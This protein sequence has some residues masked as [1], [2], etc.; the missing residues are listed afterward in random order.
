MSDMLRLTGLVSGMDTDT[1]IKKLIKV[2]QSKVDQVKQDKQFM[3]WQKEDYREIANAIRAFQDE[4]FDILKPESN[5]RSESN[6]N[7]FSGTAKID[8]ESTSKVSIETT[9]NSIVGNVTVNSVTQLATQDRYTSGAEVLGSIQTGEIGSISLVNLELADNN[10]MEFILDG[11]PKVISLDNQPY[12]DLSALA[13]DLTTKLQEAYQNVDINVSTTGTGD[14][15]LEFQIN[16]SGT[17]TEE[18]GH[19]LE[20]GEMNSDLLQKMQLKSGQSNTVNDTK[21]LAEVFDITGDTSFVI[22][23][24]TFTFS[25]DT[26]ISSVINSINT[27]ANAKVKLNYDK[28]SDKFTLEANEYGTTNSMTIVD[29]T[30]FLRKLK[31]AGG[32]EDHSVAKDS[33]ATING[34]ETT[35]SGNTFDVNGTKITVN[36]LITDDVEIEVTSDPTDTKEKIVKF[37]NAYN[38]MVR[39]INV[40]ADERKNRDFEP[41]TETQREGM[42]ETEV[43]KWEKEARKGTLGD[44]AV[45]ENITRSLRNALY[46]S[47]EGLGISLYDIGIQTSE[48]YKDKGVLTIDEEKLDDA[49]EKRP[50]EVVALFTQTSEITYSSFADRTTRDSQ[51]GIVSRIHDILQD[52]IRITRNKNGVKGYLI[53]KAGLENTE[54]KTSELAKK[55]QEMDE[56]ITN[57]LELLQNREDSLYAQFARMESAMS[58]L[59]SQS[60]WLASQFGGG[61]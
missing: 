21:T 40:K 24:E 4:Y 30:G 15:K 7:M 25:S 29:T 41:L 45:I 31:L 37:V 20:I 35:R 8:G 56:R 57:L 36:E 18:K 32:T 53:E 11:V 1:T 26:K 42:S 61:S 59:S 9:V 10:K 54:D 33:I 34:I 44:D 43:E 60:A 38:E 49:L 27:N 12:A 5:M 19:S 23:G 28:L 48:N 52:N 39:K 51:N 13:S 58:S 46:Q 16:K 47:V 2:E 14:N 50:N 17:G 22:N 6:Y 55:L 3:Q